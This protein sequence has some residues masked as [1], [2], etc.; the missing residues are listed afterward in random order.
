[1]CGTCSSIDKSM[2]LPPPLFSSYLKKD[3]NQF[4]LCALFLKISLVPLWRQLLLSKIFIVL[5]VLSLLLAIV[6]FMALLL[7]FDEMAIVIVHK[8]KSS[9]CVICDV[10]SACVLN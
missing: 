8:I 5:R 2:S 6:I 9:N 4:V 7:F 10:C 1:M 3:K